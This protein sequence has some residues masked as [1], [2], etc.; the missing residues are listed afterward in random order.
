MYPNHNS[1]LSLLRSEFIAVFIIQF[2]SLT[3]NIANVSGKWVLI[4]LFRGWRTKKDKIDFEFI[5]QKILK[6]FINFEKELFY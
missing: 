4:N 5:K 3:A 1:A 6:I 2:V